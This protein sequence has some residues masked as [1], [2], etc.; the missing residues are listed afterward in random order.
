MYMIGMR[1]VLCW[2]YR[3][4]SMRGMPLKLIQVNTK[5]TLGVTF[6]TYLWMSLMHCIAAAAAPYLFIILSCVALLTEEEFH[7]L[8]KLLI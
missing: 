1:C 7:R 4:L 6:F 8:S 3:K 5:Q 2:A